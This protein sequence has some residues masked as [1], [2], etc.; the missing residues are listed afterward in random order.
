MANPGIHIEVSKDEFL[1]K[2]QK[3]Q[4]WILYEGQLAINKHGCTYGR[5]RYRKLFAIG[6]ILGLVGGFLSGFYRKL[7]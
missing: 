6:G 3:E 4:N 5:K 1:K 7:I 2:S